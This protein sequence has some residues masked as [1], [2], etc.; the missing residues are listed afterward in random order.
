MKHPTNKW[1]AAGGGWL[2]GT[3]VSAFAHG[4]AVQGILSLFIAVGMLRV[5]FKEIK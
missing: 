5:H 1:V 4:D 3:A 2:I